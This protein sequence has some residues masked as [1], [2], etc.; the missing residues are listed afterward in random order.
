MS[1][2]N[3]FEE[4]KLRKRPLALVRGAF[5]MHSLQIVCGNYRGRI[6]SA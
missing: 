6:V 3:K 1:D 4:Y 5:C 2:G